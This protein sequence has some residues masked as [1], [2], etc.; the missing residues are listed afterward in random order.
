MM[1]ND[2]DKI[3][4]VHEIKSQSKYNNKYGF[5]M[6][7]NE[8][9]SNIRSKFFRL[10]AIDKPIKAMSAYKLNELIDICNKLVINIYNNVTSKQKSKKELY[11]SI[12]QYF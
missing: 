5:E 11:E 1:M 8:S 9:I 6:G 12:I 3:Y 4:V 2:S 10:E 7:T